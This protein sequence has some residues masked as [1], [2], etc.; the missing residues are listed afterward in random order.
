MKDIKLYAFKNKGLPGFEIVRL[1]D[2]YLTRKSILTKFHRA[3]FYHI[4]WFQEGTPTHQVDFEAISLPENSIL[5]LNSNVV[6]KFD[7]TTPFDGIGI[8]FTDDFF[9]VTELDLAFLKQSVLLN[10]LYAVSHC[11]VPHSGTELNDIARLMERTYL[12]NR[13]IYQVSLLQKYLSCFLL[14]AE[15]MHSNHDRLGALK[16]SPELDCVVAFKDLLEK[17]YKQ[18]KQ[19]SNYALDLHTTEKRLASATEKILGK[20]PKQ[21]I[22]ARV[23]LEA[24]RLLS[25]TNHSVKEVGFSLGFEE[26]TNFIKFFRKHTQQTPLAFK[27]KFLPA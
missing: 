14:L 27:E 12:G 5:F 20:T 11:L 23:I 16:K 10:Q 22:D 25:Y 18:K 26:P 21:L 13:D 17:N 2:F 19:V 8:L 4:L 9:G 24:R 3:N 1:R 7:D 15:R 6:H